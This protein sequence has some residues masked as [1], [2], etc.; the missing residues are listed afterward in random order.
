MNNVERREILLYDRVGDAVES[1]RFK[2]LYDNGRRQTGSEG[3]SFSRRVEHRRIHARRG[4]VIS[5]CNYSTIKRHGIGNEKIP[6]SPRRATKAEYSKQL[7]DP[8][9][10]YSPVLDYIH[11][12]SVYIGAPLFSMN[13]FQLVIK[14]KE[15]IS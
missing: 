14:D 1:R 10:M 2:I 6:F 5:E 13:D 12:W 4:P 3:L 11:H 7:R 9:R 8:R 15:I